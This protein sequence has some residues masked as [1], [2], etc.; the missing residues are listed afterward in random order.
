LDDKAVTHHKHK[1]GKDGKEVADDDDEEF[2]FHFHFKT[3][4]YGGFKMDESA[5]MLH[6]LLQKLDQNEHTRTKYANEVAAQHNLSLP[7]QKK[8]V[9]RLKT[10][11][12]DLQKDRS[13]FV[14]AAVDADFPTMSK[15]EQKSRL[16]ATLNVALAYAS[17]KPHSKSK[18]VVAAPT[19]LDH[20][21]AR[22]KPAEKQVEAAKPV[23]AKL[24][25]KPK[26]TGRLG[27]RLI[28]K[29]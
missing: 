1:K 4:S 18:D 29:K 15:A 8:V 12:V 16:I 9:D 22:P 6:E 26:K 7:K 24:V 21:M 28:P 17:Q 14:L 23:A 11:I 5:T 10:T 19:V 25:L 20:M 3:P 2:H 27:E 13:P